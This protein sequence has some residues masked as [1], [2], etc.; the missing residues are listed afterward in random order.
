M[1][2]LARL[3]VLLLYFL[4]IAMEVYWH[5]HRVTQLSLQVLSEV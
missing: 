5:H 1:I 3:F 4:V 2:R